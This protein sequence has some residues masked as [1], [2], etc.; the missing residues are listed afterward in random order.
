MLIVKIMVLYIDRVYDMN[1]L[2]NEEVDKVGYDDQH[3]WI[4]P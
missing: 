1:D 3:R 4:Y 2:F